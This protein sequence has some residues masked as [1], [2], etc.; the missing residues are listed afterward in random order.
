MLPFLYTLVY[1]YDVVRCLLD[2]F[3][4]PDLKIDQ[5]ADE[6][7]SVKR[8]LNPVHVIFHAHTLCAASR[9]VFFVTDFIVCR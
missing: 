8:N 3:Y 2:N 9:T 1:S 7:Y 6:S 4:L 5:F